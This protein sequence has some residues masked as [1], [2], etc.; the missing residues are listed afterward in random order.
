MRGSGVRT[1]NEG[2]IWIFT[3]WIKGFFFFFFFNDELKSVK[4]LICVQ[5]L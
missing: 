2:E 3:S 5:S 1:R 4:V